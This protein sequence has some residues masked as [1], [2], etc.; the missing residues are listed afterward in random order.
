MVRSD[1]RG[2]PISYTCGPEAIGGAGFNGGAC[3]SPPSPATFLCKVPVEL[4]SVAASCFRDM[5]LTHP[6]PARH[7]WLKML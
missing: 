4:F 1:W 3:D 7:F 5:E 6:P 2:I